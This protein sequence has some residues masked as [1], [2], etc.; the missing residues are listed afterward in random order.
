[1]VLSVLFLLCSCAHSPRPW[2]K[3]EKVAAGF[4]ILA[5]VADAYT[6]ERYLDNPNNWEEINPLLGKHP[7]DKKLTIYFS[8]T[9]LGTL[10]IGHYWPDA[11]KPLFLGYGSLNAGLAIYNTS[12]Y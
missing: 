3:D 8:V 11:R 5:H 9:G 12:L 10:L 2:T 4:F 6:T 1:M 7:S